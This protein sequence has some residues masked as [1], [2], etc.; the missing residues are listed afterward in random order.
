VSSGRG[1]QLPTIG[2]WCVY[3]AFTCIRC[4]LIDVPLE[5]ISNFT[6]IGKLGKVEVKTKAVAHFLSLKLLRL[7][8]KLHQ[9]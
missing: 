6:E 2:N 1:D 9:S 5:L 7:E 3:G 8:G 4:L